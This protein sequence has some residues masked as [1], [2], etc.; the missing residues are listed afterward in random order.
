MSSQKKLDSRVLGND[1][2]FSRFVELSLD[3]TAIDLSQFGLKNQDKIVLDISVYLE[4][5]PMVDDPG[6]NEVYVPKMLD[7]VSEVLSPTQSIQKIF[8]RE[9][10]KVLGSRKIYWYLILDSQVFTS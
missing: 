4:S 6:E 3:T 8:R 5:P 7:L 9:R 2:K 1:E 10:K